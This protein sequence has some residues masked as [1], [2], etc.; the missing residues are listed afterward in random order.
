MRNAQKPLV[1]REA[2]CQG[3][4]KI[5]P[6]LGRRNGAMRKGS[7]GGGSYGKGC[8]TTGHAGPPMSKSEGYGNGGKKGK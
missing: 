7:K 6:A 8:G 5:G 3:F 4:L 2:R 1:S